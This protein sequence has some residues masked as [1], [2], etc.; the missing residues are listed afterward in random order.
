[1]VERY[2]YGD[3]GRLLDGTTLQPLGGSAIGN[4]YFFTG[5]RQDYESKWYYMRNRYFMPGKAR[6]TT[7]DPIGIWGDAGNLG[8]AVAYVSNNP[9]RFVDPY[10]LD[11]I[12]RLFVDQPVPGSGAAV[13]LSMA[14]PDVGHVFVQL[15]HPKAGETITAGFYPTEAGGN[16]GSTGEI[17]DDTMSVSDADVVLEFTISDEAYEFAIDQLLGDASDPEVYDLTDTSDGDSNNCGDWALGFTEAVTGLEFDDECGRSPLGSNPRKVGED[18]VNRY[19]ARRIS[20][21]SG[22]GEDGTGA[23]EGDGASP[24]ENGGGQDGERCMVN[25]GGSIG[26]GTPPTPGCM[27]PAFP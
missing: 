18:L 17:R 23:P 19:G 6:F 7:R 4:P 25:N 3:F 9:W 10:G 5:A 11:K 2:D 26:G 12:L 15:H 1:V 27:Y 24:A 22:G 8:N 20:Q 21:E 14:G 13:A 16:Y